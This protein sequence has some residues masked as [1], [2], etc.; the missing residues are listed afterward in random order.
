M[1]PLDSK[2]KRTAASAKLFF[3]SDICPEGSDSG[4]LDCV[5][6]RQNTAFADVIV[7]V[8]GMCRAVGMP[9]QISGSSGWRRIKHEEVSLHE[10]FLNTTGHDKPMIGNFDDL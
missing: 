6:R 9:L 3:H 10:K 5:T 7:F 4:R 8:D 2:E 1:P